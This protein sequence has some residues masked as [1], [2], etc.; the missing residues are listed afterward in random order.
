[1]SAS[2]S[3]VTGC[4][5]LT[6]VLSGFPAY[7]E[8]LA[9]TRLA[10]D[11]FKWEQGQFGISRAFLVGDERKPGMYMYRI[12]FPANYKVQP[13][14][15]SDERVITVMS[16]TFY[17]GYG[18]KFDENDMKVLPAGSA[19]TEPPNK[20]HFAFAKDGEVIIQVVG[21]NGPSVTTRIDPK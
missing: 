14:F 4:V 1:M 20:P 6:F 7:T 3:Q 16:G 2:I 8:P 11:D 10:P 21:S 13:H 15:H 18:E 17:M 9:P 12:R 19:W 5:V